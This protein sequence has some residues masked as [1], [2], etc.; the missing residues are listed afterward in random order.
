MP[1][2][3]SAATTNFGPFVLE[4][5]IAVGGS[6]EVYLAHPKSGTTPAPRLVVKRLL[7][8]QTEDQFNVLSHEADLHRAV[9]HPNVV[10]VF[11]AGMV[12]QEP[13]LAMEYVEGVD[14]FRLLRHAR[15]EER[16]L[17]MGVAVHVVRC[18]AE[19]LTAVHAA[20]SA[21]GLD[22][23]I[24]HRDVTPSNVYLS[25][26][27]DVK[28]GDF[29]IARVSE[30][31]RPP[32]GKPGLKGK[33]G[34]VA[35]EQI[36]GEPFDHRADLFALTAILGELLI[37]ERVFPGEGQLAVLLAIR[38]G[39]TARLEEKRRELPRDLYAICERGLARDPDARFQTASELASALEPFEQPSAER[40]RE[41]LAHWV[42]QASD[43]K[44]M[45]RQI[46]DSVQRMRAVGLRARTGEAPPESVPPPE[47]ARAVAEAPR[48]P[49]QRE[50]RE[51]DGE[52]RAA[53]ERPT[54]AEELA[55]PP[56][57]DPEPDRSAPTSSEELSP[58]PATVRSDAPDEPP[59][60][61]APTGS[62]GAVSVTRSDGRR[63]DDL[64]LARLLELVATGELGEDDLVSFN[65]APPRRI[66][67]VPD[68]ARHLMPSTTQT[69]K[70]LF[71]L[72][73]PDIRALLAE[74][75]M[76]KVL[77][78]L[79][80][81]GLTGAVFVERA[82][83]TGAPQRKELYLRGGRLLHVASSDRSE[84]LGE[85]LVRRKS[86]SREQLDMA[87]ASLSTFGG[88]LG[89]TVIGLGYV[90]A[91][92]V[93]RAI[94][95]QGRDRVAALCGW[96]RG[97]VS[98]YKGT[99]PGR[100]EFPLDL[101][102]AS[103]IMAGAIVESQGEPRKLLPADDAP[104]RPGPR[105]YRAFDPS[106]QGTAP[107]SLRMIPRLVGTHASVGQ[108]LD[109]LTRSGDTRRI[110]DKEAAAALIAARTLDWVSY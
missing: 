73:T 12:G 99:D 30:Q 15:L 83:R 67:D 62:E 24:V 41:Q 8:G 18:L 48:P 13:Y 1:N 85:Y 110:G 40:L 90:D 93:F 45:A 21:D 86:I 80:Q 53:R 35:P 78:Q 82:D 28:L 11:G 106:E 88:R 20:K 68:L 16:K 97:T 27:G 4:R 23:G 101:D 5:R 95:D 37:G 64:T 102:L 79:R 74:T 107:R 14:L 100:V 65:G 105:H 46:H 98:F 70:Q 51:M 71:K 54:Q 75:R 29:G 42:R 33:F 9:D 89:D 3:G 103:P 59:A 22:L 25:V 63:I 91:V 26:S 61:P 72:G 44:R 57:P 76:M 2:P 96:K 34:Y 60:A 66:A 19:A 109:E 47:E 6:A 52:E 92:D 39:N 43:E 38:D 84:L 87:L 108:M 7:S 10:R 17:S 36:T 104:I 69:T 55:P 81:D 50:I 32:S 49:P 77:A 56:S 31:I 94:R 58:A